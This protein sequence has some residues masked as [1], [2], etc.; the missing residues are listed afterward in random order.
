MKD[1]WGNELHPDIEAYAASRGTQEDMI[2]PVLR[3]QQWYS[4]GS[5]DAWKD[6]LRQI[7]LDEN[8]YI[9]YGPNSLVNNSIV[10][11]KIPKDKLGL[12]EKILD[13]KHVTGELKQFLGIPQL[14]PICL[15]KQS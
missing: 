9:I 4:P 6:S 15:G 13:G 14:P 1:C 7:E 5:H 11:G 3:Y 12:L 8:T 2:A 10:W